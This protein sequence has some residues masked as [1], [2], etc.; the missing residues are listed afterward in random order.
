MRPR[1]AP[2]AA[3]LAVLLGACSGSTDSHA[4]EGGPTLPPAGVF[5]DGLIYAA[6]KARLAGADID[7]TTR[8]SVIVHGGVVTLRGTVKDAATKER[9]AKLVAAMRGVKAV[10]DELR[11]GQVGPSAAQAV[12]NAALVAAVEGALAAQAGIN[13]TGISVRAD[14]G[15]VTLSGRAP[16]AAIKSTLVAAARQ[17]PG[18]RNV[19]DRIAVR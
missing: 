14:A 2:A 9:E 12:R 4:P 17:A 3:A 18:V 8:I 1:A 11:V 10:N 15:T 6:V 19:V 7:S 16:T 5:K 13:V